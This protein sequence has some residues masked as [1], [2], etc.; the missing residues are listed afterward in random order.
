MI[1]DTLDRAGRYGALAPALSEAFHWLGGADPHSLEAGRHEI[2][3]E[4]LFVLVQSYLTEEASQ[5]RLE[6]H[7]RYL[8]IQYVARGREIIY[9]APEPGL[10]VIQEYDPDGDILFLDGEPQAELRVGTGSFALFLPGDAHKPRCRW[11]ASE[12]VR[13]LVLKVLLD[14]RR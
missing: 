3:G 13:K 2:D 5:R 11:E 10:P 1:L 4:R 9:W 7:R 8:D 12:E 14:P 6:A